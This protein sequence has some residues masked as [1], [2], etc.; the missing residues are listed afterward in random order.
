[1]LSDESPARPFHV[2]RFAALL[3]SVLLA[4]AAVGTVLRNSVRQR[5]VGP[6]GLA[7]IAALV[8][9]TALM[10]LAATQVFGHYVTNLF[11]FVVVALLP[12]SSVTEPQP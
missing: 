8:V 4:L 2:L 7:F 12:A 9:N 5:S 6:F 1:M 3:V 11:P 10:G